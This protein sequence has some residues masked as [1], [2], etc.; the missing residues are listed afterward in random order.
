MKKVLLFLFFFLNTNP[1]I[2]EI[3]VAKGTYKHLG[4]LSPKKACELAEKRAKENAIK[5]ALGLKISLDEVQT[6][7]EVDGKL[8]CEQNQTSI[9]SLNGDITEVLVTNKNDGIDELLILK[10]IFVK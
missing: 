6:C 9:L 5:E 8:D 10:F 3:I 7:K 1:S 2:A 4:D